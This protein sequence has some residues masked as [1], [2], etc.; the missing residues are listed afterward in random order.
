MR[1][2]AGPA[3]SAAARSARLPC[4]SG[5]ALIARSL[6]GASRGAEAR[7]EF[8][9]AVACLGTFE[10]K[11]E[12]AIWAYETGDMGAAQRLH[13]DLDE[14]PSAGIPSSRPERRGDAG[15]ARR[16]RCRRKA[17]GGAGLSRATSRQPFPRL[18]AVRSVLRPTR[19][20]PVPRLR[21]VSMIAFAICGPPTAKPYRQETTP[22]SR[23]FSSSVCHNECALTLREICTSSGLG[24]PN[25]SRK[26]ETKPRSFL[27]M[28]SST[29]V[30]P[31]SHGRDCA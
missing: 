21:R 25:P 6:A 13:A 7:L 8:E 16:A 17:G 5:V 9:S 12:Y 18:P 30:I 2:C 31:L 23:D 28:G 22:A 4:G 1:G 15:P 26:R 27:G 10:A 29:R 14:I 3:R 11:A 19:A 20:R 24:V